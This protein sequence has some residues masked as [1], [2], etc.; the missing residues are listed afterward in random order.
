MSS[1]Q[2]KS[3]HS[4]N[5]GS[6]NTWDDWHL[7]PTSRPRIEPPSVKTN[8]LDIS[9]GDGVLDMTDLLTNRIY[10]NR[11]SGSWTFIVVNDGQIPY[12]GTFTTWA[13]LYSEI[14]AYLHGKSMRV[15][16]D[17]DPNYFYEGRFSVSEWNSAKGNST[18]TINYSLSP[19]K[20]LVSNT[21][22]KRF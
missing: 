14:M 15:I 6:K 21:N 22:G 7:V 1:N 16:L 3:F 19:Y 18:I 17:D 9:G 5:F 4:V 11:R 12:N 10:Y 2:A 20:K 8:Y 13:E